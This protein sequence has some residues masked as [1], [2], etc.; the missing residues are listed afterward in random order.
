V[1]LGMITLALAAATIAAS[2][3]VHADPAADPAVGVWQVYSDKTG[4]ADGRVRTFLQDGKLTGVVE[5]LPPDAPPDVRCT[6][7]GGA[8]KDKPVLGLVVLWGLHKDGASWS[9]GSILE[10]QSGSTYRC[11]ATLVSPDALE[12]RGYVGISLLGR[13]Q[14]WKRVH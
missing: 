8:Q 3:P 5:Q 10:P 4:A 1:K 12:V 9:E 11:N 14:T 13:T 7:C 6:K 2:S